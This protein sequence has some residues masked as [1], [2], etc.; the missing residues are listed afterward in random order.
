M[1]K[2]GTKYVVKCINDAKLPITS[3]E[4]VKGSEMKIAFREMIV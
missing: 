3:L 4:F 1:S 2:W